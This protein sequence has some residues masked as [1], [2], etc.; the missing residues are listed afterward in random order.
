MMLANP[1]VSLTA[2]GARVLG[3]VLRGGARTVLLRRLLSEIAFGAGIA[4]TLWL[5]AHFGLRAVGQA[6]SRI[7]LGGIILVTLARAPALTCLGLCW[8]LL[9]GA[10]GGKHPIKFVWGRMM[11]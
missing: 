8:W 10:T 5:I 9:A 11:R 1:G 4:L 7:G 3:S 2:R 6:F